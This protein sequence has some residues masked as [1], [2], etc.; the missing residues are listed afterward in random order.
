MKIIVLPEAEMEMFEAARYYE[1][2]QRD[3]G[4]RF[5]NA[6]ES[7]KI[8][9]EENPRRWPVIRRRFR[10]RLL[11]YFPYG[12]IYRIRRDAITLVAVMHLHRDPG[13]WR[14]RV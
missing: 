7:A 3:L 2:R 1:R 9:I 8:D 12:I 6:V 5:L 11:G 10:R 14:K 4:K 13:Y